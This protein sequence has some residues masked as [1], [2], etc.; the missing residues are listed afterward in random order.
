M[1]ENAAARKIQEA[2]R[3]SRKFRFVLYNGTLDIG[4]Q[5]NPA[6]F[7]STLVSRPP[8][9]EI[10]E[11]SLVNQ[12]YRTGQLQKGDTHS[13]KLA[14]WTRE[15]GIKG[16]PT[17]GFA[18]NIK[19]IY[20]GVGHSVTIYKNGKIQYA[21]GYPKSGE[22][23][24]F[25]TPR[26]VL[27]I[28]FPGQFTNADINLNNVML[29]RS[30]GRI[31]KNLERASLLVGGSYEPEMRTFIK[32][33]RPK[34]TIQIFKKG[35]IQ[36]LRLSDSTDVSPAMA[37]ANNI[38][39]QISNANLLGGVSVS[40]SRRGISQVRLN[41]KPAPEIRR[42]TTTVPKGKRPSPFSF[43]GT[44]PNGMYLAPNPQ[45]EPQCY[46]VPVRIA[47]MKPKIIE[48]FEKFGLKIPQ[49]TK[50]VFGILD[51]N[52]SSRPVNVSGKDAGYRFTLERMQ[53]KETNKRFLKAKSPSGDR[54]DRTVFKI[55]SRQASR[56][57]SKQLVDI[58]MRL[59]LVQY[60]RTTS[61]K[62]LAGAIQKYA[63]SKGLIETHQYN[64]NG[65][66]RNT[67]Y[68]GTGDTFKVGKRLCLSYSKP[69][70]A[71]IAL[72]VYGKRLDT[73]KTLK[74]LCMEVEDLAQAR[75]PSIAS[76]S[77]G[78]SNFEQN[79]IEAM[80]VK[81]PVKN[82]FSD[83]TVKQL[84]AYLSTHGIKQTS[85]D[86][87]SL[88]KLARNK[89]VQKVKSP[90][91]KI[92]LEFAK[93][94]GFYVKAG[95]KKE[96]VKNLL[97]KHIAAKIIQTAFRSKFKPRPKSVPKKT[98]SPPPFRRQMMAYAPV[99]SMNSPSPSPPKPQ[100]KNLSRDNARNILRTHLKRSNFTNV[101][102]DN[103]RTQA[104]RY[105]KYSADPSKHIKR[106][107][108]NMF[109]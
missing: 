107:M 35:V 25:S 6:A 12:M 74:Q 82:Q 87:E 49:K 50:I 101:E 99:E 14:S 29:Q 52:N 108:K 17:K 28:I 80:A 60:A 3:R 13:L 41:N 8:Q 73:E 72:K 54:Y 51:V 92:L 33:E 38:Y 94:R 48:R 63:E 27:N 22:S 30:T 18:C 20:A 64:P 86:K 15:Y 105:I 21:G 66:P 61:R 69:A 56:Y 95:T 70:L 32:V 34:W 31:I 4:R 109:G 102:L 67:N 96:Q 77:S 76:A 2:F 59:G 23:G 68:S 89:A 44:C 84:R 85:R 19:I 39:T 65:I 36:I 24:W 47:Y 81:S 40:N 83:M 11:V 10:K 90:P 42:R 100:P 7:F 43:A 97:E 98:P 1:S 75:A 103:F 78:L 53:R 9:S 71:K 62:I 26:H 45:G 5:I 57:T 88:L 46:K 16:D 91:L 106:L 79:L 37:D 93:H 55:D 104:S 58:C